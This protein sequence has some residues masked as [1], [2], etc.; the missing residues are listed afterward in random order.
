[1][2]VDSSNYNT[3]SN[4]LDL[5]TEK[6]LYYPISIYRELLVIPPSTSGGAPEAH[7]T[8]VQQVKE[9]VERDYV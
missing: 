7:K 1:M 6:L 4:R 9:Q 2:K 3:I 8:K 5:L